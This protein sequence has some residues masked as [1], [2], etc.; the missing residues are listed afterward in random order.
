M[1]NLDTDTVVYSD[2]ADE[3]LPMASPDQDHD[4]YWHHE[5]HPRH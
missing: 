2:N 1:L 5:E 4:L 3:Q